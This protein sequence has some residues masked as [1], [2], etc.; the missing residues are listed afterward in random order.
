V[1]TSDE[2]DVESV[3]P[4][5]V[6]V[7]ALRIAVAGL[8]LL[9]GGAAIAGRDALGGWTFGIVVVAG[10][11][12]LALWGVRNARPRIGAVLAT[13]FAV[14]GAVMGATGLDRTEGHVA[15][16]VLGRDLP[17]RAVYAL[18]LAF[19]L[20]AVGGA[21]LAVLWRPDRGGSGG[22]SG[23]GRSS[24]RVVGG[25]VVAA[26]VLSSG[27]L[28]GASLARS[29]DDRRMESTALHHTVTRPAEQSSPG[30]G[31][32]RPA[33]QAWTTD[34]PDA[35]VG[36]V[37][38][39]GVPGW[40][41]VLLHE[42]DLRGEAA[43]SRL[44]ALSAT[45]GSELWRYERHGEFDG[46][47][48]DPES[49]RVLLVSRSAAIVLSLENGDEL[50]TRPLRDHLACW[51]SVGDRFTDSD[52]V[53]LTIKVRPTAVMICGD[54]WDRPP[55][56]QP[57]IV[58]MIDVATGTVTAAGDSPG[59]H[60]DCTYATPPATASPV[61]VRWGTDAA[62]DRSDCG[63]PALLAPDSTG[64]I[65]AIAEIEPPAEATSEGCRRHVD[66]CEASR[67]VAADD[68]IVLALDWQGGPSSNA[69]DEAAPLLDLV[70]LSP[71]GDQLWRR[72]GDDGGGSAVVA[73]DR[74]AVVRDGT[75]WRLLSLDDGREL[76]RS[77]DRGGDAVLDSPAAPPVSD[78]EHVYAYT[79]DV[80]LV[81]RST[82][83][84]SPL[85]T[86]PDIE[87]SIYEPFVASGLVVVLRLVGD[88]RDDYRLVA[89]ADR[90]DRSDRSN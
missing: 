12:V 38:A 43:T 73:T 67:V 81:V 28:A 8:A 57:E 16:R 18:T 21:A 88:E 14:V 48:A 25:G 52:H 89:Y 64:E 40:D 77:P 22:T 13:A 10:A 7:G 17:P 63:L 37:A 31:P 78:G 45:D 42:D 15:S 83:D 2:P 53:D 54:E 71:D 36:G 51:R 76:A 84:L 35:R 46:V 85:A 50:I 1:G 5:A 80:G 74:G 34:L 75:E 90:S 68:T 49:G 23:P 44:V 70:A 61:V 47:T 26:V 24:R 72:T 3:P 33:R 79:Y 69:D 82:D 56:D 59:D 6:A 41:V 4:A 55:A 65:R 11:V 20:A 86:A 29:L 19:A 27:T 62:N 39:A 60:G 66:T 58:A 87:S 9:A 32:A 30:P